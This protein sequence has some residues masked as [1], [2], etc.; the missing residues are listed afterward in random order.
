MKAALTRLAMRT[1]P[2]VQG[3]MDRRILV[4]LRVRPEVAARIIPKPLVPRIVAGWNIAG[5]CMIRLDDMRIAGVPSWLGRGSENSAH[6]FAVHWYANGRIK[7]GVYIPDRDTDSQINH[8]VGGRL[9]PG[10]HHLADFTAWESEGR[11][12]V[13]FSRRNGACGVKVVARTAD[14]WPI[15]SVFGSLAEASEFYHSGCVGWS[16]RPGD[17]CLDGMELS[18]NQWAMKPLLVERFESTYFQNRNLFPAGSVEFDSACLMR[19]VRHR[20]SACGF[21]NLEKDTKNEGNPIHT[22]GGLPQP[23]T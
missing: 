18:C 8:L 5:V 15:G 21:L 9:F 17:D 23:G 10:V 12:R 3:L 4:A 2:G 20:W 14:D 6:R 1:M 7:E 13:G 11:F 22:T 19:G 16:A